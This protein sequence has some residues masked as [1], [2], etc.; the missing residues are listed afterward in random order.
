MLFFLRKSCEHWRRAGAKRLAA[1]AYNR[2][3]SFPGPYLR[4]YPPRSFAA[5]RRQHGLKENVSL[6]PTILSNI[7]VKG[8]VSGSCIARSK[9]RCPPFFG[10]RNSFGFCIPQFLSNLWYKLI[11]LFARV[12]G[13]TRFPWRELD[14]FPCSDV[15]HNS[16]SSSLAGCY[17]GT[18]FRTARRDLVT[19]SRTF[20]AH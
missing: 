16:L 19:N 20:C 5:K 17:R 9:P 18:I 10:P 13:W 12:Y 3:T 2:A 4:S 7:D 14:K 8:L 11:F 1:R 6:F 15:M